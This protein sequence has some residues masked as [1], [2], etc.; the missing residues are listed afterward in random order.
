MLGHDGHTGS[1]LAVNLRP[2]IEVIY[3]SGDKQ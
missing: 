3:E 1:H 2:E